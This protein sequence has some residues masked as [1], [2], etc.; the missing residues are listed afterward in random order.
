MTSCTMHT[1]LLTTFHIIMHYISGKEEYYTEPQKTMGV[2]DGIS[3][4]VQTCMRAEALLGIILS[5]HRVG[6]LALAYLYY[7]SSGCP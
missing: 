7:Y 1:N 2:V 3:K 6:S 5:R 4:F